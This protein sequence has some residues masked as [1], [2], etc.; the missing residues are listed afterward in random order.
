MLGQTG[1]NSGCSLRMAGP[2]EAI[3]WSASASAA[4]GDGALGPAALVVGAAGLVDAASVVAAALAAGAVMSA[5]EAVA[6][7]ESVVVVAGAAPIEAAT[8]WGKR[9]ARGPS[10]RGATST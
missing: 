5:V 9:P 10:V 7:V 2:S 4:A 8:S 3:C 6:A 1:A